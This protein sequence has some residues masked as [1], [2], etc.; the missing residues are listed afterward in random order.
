[1]PTRTVT[2]KTTKSTPS[3]RSYGPPDAVVQFHVAHEAI[4]QPFAGLMRHLQAEQLTGDAEAIWRAH[5]NLHLATKKLARCVGP[6]PTSDGKSAMAVGIAVVRAIREVREGLLSRQTRDTDVISNYH[7]GLETILRDI[8]VIDVVACS[9]AKIVSRLRV[10]EQDLADWVQP[11]LQTADH[12]RFVAVDA[13]PDLETRGM[14]IKMRARIYGNA[15][16]GI[17]D[18]L[19]V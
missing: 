15:D 17:L 2:P 3:K 16:L 18:R 1:M 14:R 11:H 8:C 19:G 5:P 12:I 7:R 13:S 6:C 4:A 9:E 10:F